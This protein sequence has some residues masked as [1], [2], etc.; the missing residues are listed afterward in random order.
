[1]DRVGEILDKERENIGQRG[2]I[3]DRE[4]KYRMERENI[5]QRG[6]VSDRDG[7]YWV[8]RRNIA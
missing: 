3:L 7:K 8:E 6:K 2:V 5:G 1:M 4:D